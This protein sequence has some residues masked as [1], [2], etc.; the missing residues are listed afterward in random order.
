MGIVCREDD[1]VILYDISLHQ[2]ARWLAYKNISVVVAR[3]SGT[4]VKKW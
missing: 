3:Q 4:S 2:I 1:A